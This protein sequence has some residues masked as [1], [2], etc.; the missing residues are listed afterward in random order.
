MKKIFSIVFILIFGTVCFAQKNLSVNIDNEIYNI[1]DVAEMKGFCD[2]LPSA[3]PYTLARILK[4]VDQILEH[5]DELK[6]EEIA[7]LEDFKKSNEINTEKKNGFTHLA[8]ESKTDEDN[9]HFSFLYDFSLDTYVSGGFYND[10]DFN[11]AG[12]DI[13]PKVD[14]RG[15]I[16]K[17]VSYSFSGVFDITYM[18]LYEQGETFVGYNWYGYDGYDYD[19]STGN[20]KYS[21]YTDDELESYFDGD[22][23]ENGENYSRPTPRKIKKYKNN[24]YLPYSYKKPWDG[25]VYLL[26]D[27]S[28]S[29]TEG[30][31][32]EFGVS[33]GSEGEIRSSLLGER[34]TIGAGRI[35]HEWAAMDNGSSLVL[36]KAA[37][38]FFELS[39]SVEIFDWLKFSSL[40]GILEYPNSDYILDN[41][42][43]EFE[44][45]SYPET[46]QN[47]DD[48]F[49]WQN[50][51]SANMIE[52]DFKYFHFD[53]GSTVVYPKRLE[54]GYM[55]PLFIY[56]EYQNHTGDMDNLALFGDIMIRKPGLGKLWASIYLDEINGLNNDPFT[57]TRAMFA[58]Q[59]G[60]KAV[61]PWLPFSSVSVRYTKVEPYCYTHH[62][63]NYAPSYSHYIMEGYMNNGASLGYYLPPNADEFFFRFETKPKSSVTAALQ[64]QFI[65]HGADFGSQE[66]PGSSLYSELNIYN[67]DELEKYFLHD[68]A[69]NWM[70]IVKLECAFEHR[71]VERTLQFT[72]S[73]GFLYSYYTVIDDKDYGRYDDDNYGNNENCKNA[74]FSTP[75]H[76]VNTDEYPV[77]FGVVAGLGLKILF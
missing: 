47:L 35:S 56:V 3:K 40:T 62:S 29:G 20:W 19:E 24:S 22:K 21:P 9:L 50:A 6:P 43:S 32:T 51:F 48:S 46:K 59:V 25:Q 77:Q 26:S 15:D 58:G 12:F 30:W 57:S 64:Y 72:T 39:S 28:A 18:P 7:I 2:F 52:L 42:G 17:Y 49:Y 33:G 74:S 73:L 4:A 67:R 11:S 16:T 66:V 61:V 14:F 71:S 55:F 45:S 1:L 75:Y 34:F 53:F 23:K 27:M 5:E 37:R 10:S 60:A 13:M 68:G 31:A 54:L 65:R 69:Y 38:P 63:I 41:D 36:N 44:D 8:L 70:H 76:F